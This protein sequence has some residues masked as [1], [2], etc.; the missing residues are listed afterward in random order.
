ML[1]VPFS[2]K[3]QQQQKTYKKPAQELCMLLHE[4]FFKD[5]LDGSGF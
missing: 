5:S 1:T 3:Q 4:W 2:V